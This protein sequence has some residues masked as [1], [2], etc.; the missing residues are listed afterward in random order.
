MLH[1][2]CI[3][4]PRKRKHYNKIKFGYR[5]IP[6][7]RGMVIVSP[8][9]G[10]DFTKKDYACKNTDIVFL[11]CMN[12]SFGQMTENLLTLYGFIIT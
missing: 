7:G 6:Y 12:G 8:A 11:Y 3:G 1:K 2:V 4:R 9:Y 5:L 10:D